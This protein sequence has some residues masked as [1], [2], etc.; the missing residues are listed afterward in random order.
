M[1]GWYEFRNRD[2][3]PSEGRWAERDPLGFGG[4]ELN[5]YQDTFSS[6]INYTDPI[7][8]GPFS[9]IV[10]GQWDPPQD[11]YNAA[12]EG[13]GQGYKKSYQVVA[14]PASMALSVASLA[15]GPVGWVASGANLGL[16]AMDP[17]IEPYNGPYLAAVTPDGK[18]VVI[19]TPRV[20]AGPMAPS[21]RVP[22]GPSGMSPR[23]PIG[24][25][26]LPT[27]SVTTAK[28]IS[29]PSPNCPAQTTHHQ[30]GDQHPQTL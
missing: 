11:I 14:P 3:I 5:L 9:W 13:Y 19:I 4:G 27:R 1:T 17:S 12:M 25:R 29:R 15:K 30:E 8:F 18:P 6:P 10:T 7:G 26:P 16:V 20:P 28:G 21:M 2:L 23:V 22:A 24:P